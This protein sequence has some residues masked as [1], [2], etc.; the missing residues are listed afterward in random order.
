M[1]FVLRNVLTHLWP[2]GQSTDYDPDRL[3]L[4]AASRATRRWLTS[5]ASNDAVAKQKAVAIQCRDALQT[6]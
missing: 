5:E 3:A 6:R 2:T 1:Q 4:L